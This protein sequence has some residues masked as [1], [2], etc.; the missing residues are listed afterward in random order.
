MKFI[1]MRS[2]ASLVV[3]L[4][5]LLLSFFAAVGAPEVEAASHQNLTLSP[6]EF[7]KVRCSTSGDPSYFGWEGTVYAQLPG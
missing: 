3:G 1:D 2:L 6:E 5:S 7:M 4:A